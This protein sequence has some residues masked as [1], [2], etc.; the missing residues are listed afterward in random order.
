MAGFCRRTLAG[1]RRL[2]DGAALRTT[3][4]SPFDES[5]AGL[6][7]DSIPEDR[8]L[9]NPFL[10]GL[11]K[12]AAE[13]DQVVKTE[14]WRKS[15]SP[16]AG[17][18]SLGGVEV[19]GER[20]GPSAR[21]NRPWIP[22]RAST[23]WQTPASAGPFPTR[24]RSVCC[25][26]TKLSRVSRDNRSAAAWRSPKA[27]VCLRIFVTRRPRGSRR[28]GESLSGHRVHGVESTSAR[29]TCSVLNPGLGRT[30]E[31]PPGFQDPPE[32]SETYQKQTFGPVAQ[33]VRAE[34]S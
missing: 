34:D 23:E 13:C 27:W 4:R 16:K 24:G 25:A 10:A 33:S 5:V 15:V 3:R 21:R 2:L 32:T 18:Q 12:V 1:C 11:G 9:L 14:V 19:A 22:L 29:G 20:Q 30:G 6:H 17:G 7:C 8:M 31:V 26:A 28:R